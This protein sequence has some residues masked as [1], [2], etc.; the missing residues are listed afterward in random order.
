MN[1]A[2]QPK[3]YILRR[4]NFAVWPKYNN[5][6]HFSFPVALK[7]K[8]LMCSSCQYFKNFGKS[9]SLNSMLTT[10]LW[11][12]THHWFTKVSKTPEKLLS[13]LF[14]HLHFHHVSFRK[15]PGKL[16]IQIPI[17]VALFFYRCVFKGFFRSILISRFMIKGC[18]V[19]FLT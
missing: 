7:I 17:I 14:H 16:N 8:L 9:R 13:G 2:V 12:F 5:L 15:V 19:F 11:F 18:N 10:Y 3:Y 4:F 1:F 6:R